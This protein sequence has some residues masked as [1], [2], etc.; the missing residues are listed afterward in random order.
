M[1]LGLLV[2]AYALAAGAAVA[3]VAAFRLAAFSPPADVSPAL[4][5]LMAAVSWVQLAIWAAA[6]GC[7]VAVGVKL[8]RRVKA[9]ITW[10][11]AFLLDLVN[12][13]WLRA[14]GWYDAAIPPQLLYADYA[15]IGALLLTGALILALGRTHLD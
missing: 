13:L 15:V 14:D 7:Y 11:A 9:F 5:D 10:S 4:L 6:V 3:A 2:L 1:L 12:W 8:V